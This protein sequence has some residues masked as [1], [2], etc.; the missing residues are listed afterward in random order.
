MV[1]VVEVQSGQRAGFSLYGG[2]LIR[3]GWKVPIY[4]LRVRLGS[5]SS[6]GKYWDTS[7]WKTDA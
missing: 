4:D 2:K 1:V 6:G 7:T 3:L 5:S